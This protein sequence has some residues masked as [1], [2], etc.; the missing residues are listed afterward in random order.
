MSK[1][2]KPIL[3]RDDSKWDKGYVII[4]WPLKTKTCPI[5]GGEFKKLTKD[6]WCKGCDQDAKY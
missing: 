5:C 2:R 1:G 6:G 3:G 4:K